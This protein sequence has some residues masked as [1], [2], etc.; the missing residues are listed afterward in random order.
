MPMERE[1]IREGKK[2][3]QRNAAVNRNQKNEAHEGQ[4]HAQLKKTNA[5]VREQFAKEQPHR[6]D[7]RDEKLLERAALFLP[8]NREGGE[9]GGDIQKQNRGQPRQKEIRGAGVGIEKNLWPHVNGEGSE[10]VLKNAAQGF[11]QADGSRDVDGLTGD[12]GIRPVDEHQDLRAH[13]VKKAIGVVDGDFD[14][15][16]RPAGNDGIVESIVVLNVAHDVKRI[17]VFQAIQ[18]FPAL[19]ATVGVINHRV[20][21]TDVGVDRETQ[22]DHLQQR[23]HQREKERG[24]ITADV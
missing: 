9:K 5:E 21:L 16:A 20:D 15:Y 3:E 1:K 22:N 7:R 12:G 14:A 24:R 8:H 11:I 6:T 13:V 10:A 17:R 23:N 19:A 4:N 2:R 18:Q